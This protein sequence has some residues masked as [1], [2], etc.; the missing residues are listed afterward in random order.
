DPCIPN[1][2]GGNG[3]TAGGGCTR[4]ATTGGFKC[5]TCT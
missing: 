3:D 2:C 1:P 4:L 5:T